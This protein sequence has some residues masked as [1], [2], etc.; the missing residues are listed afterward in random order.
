MDEL[1]DLRKKK[2][3]ELQN[4]AQSHLQAALHHEEKVAQQIAYL[5]SIVKP[6]LSKD[7][8]TRYGTIKTVHPEKAAQV[9]L[10]LAQYVDKIDIITDVQFK[11]VLLRMEQPKRETTIK[12]I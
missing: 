4:Q 10:V 1:S 3:T 5:E 11:E 7:A 9:M 2:I 8:L 6:K 12:R